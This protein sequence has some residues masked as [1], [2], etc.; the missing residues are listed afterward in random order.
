MQPDHS[1]L[2]DLIKWT[3]PLTPHVEGMQASLSPTPSLLYLRILE[4]AVLLIFAF[5]LLETFFTVHLSFFLCFLPAFVSVIFLDIIQIFC[6]L[7]SWQLRV[8]HKILWRA[9]GHEGKQ[10][11]YKWASDVPVLKNSWLFGLWT[12]AVFRTAAA[13]AKSLQSCPTLWDPING[14]PPGSTIPG[15]LQAGALEWAAISFSRAWKWKVKVKSLSLVGL[16]ST[17]WTAAY[18]APPSVGFSRQEHWS[19]VPWP[20]PSSRLGG[21][22]VPF[23]PTSK[24]LSSCA[25]G[26]L[27][28][29]TN[30]CLLLCRTDL[31]LGHFLPHYSCVPRILFTAKMAVFTRVCSLRWLLT[32]AVKAVFV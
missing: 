29:S 6:C 14:S 8:V 20:S 5:L 18:Q 30:P 16:F 15:I 23:L 21:H 4:G 17:P 9:W 24:L 11:T 13:A 28:K 32:V 26:L 19:G 7:K 22:K 2:W 27:P 3:Q 12:A 10:I 1:I 25:Q 31:L